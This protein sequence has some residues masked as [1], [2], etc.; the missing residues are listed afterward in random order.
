MLSLVWSMVA[1]CASSR[2]LSHI[3]DYD[4][5]IIDSGGIYE[6][7]SYLSN[8]PCPAEPVAGSE[9]TGLAIALAAPL[10]EKGVEL[11]V[12]AAMKKISAYGN[13]LAQPVTVQSETYPGKD[14]LSN[15]DRVGCVLVVYGKYGGNGTSNIGDAKPL[16]PYVGSEPSKHLTS[17][18][19]FA[20]QIGIDIT[21][22]KVS[23]TPLHLFYPKA[24]HVGSSS[25]VHSLTVEASVGSEKAV[26]KF[27]N[28]KAGAYYDYR[29]LAAHKLTVDKKALDSGT[30]NITVIE[31]PDNQALGEA[32]ADFAGDKELK[33]KLIDELQKVVNKQLDEPKAQEGQ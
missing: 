13:Y 27:E 20:M 21:G 12:D 6:L 23:L 16:R 3:T 5:A 19:G 18:V 33:K 25:Q 14:R 24:F 32:L 11:A 29:S 31:G 17:N 7:R 22:Q 1:G 2:D 15:L 9:S 10:L 28:V 8:S 30:I 26:M 4:A